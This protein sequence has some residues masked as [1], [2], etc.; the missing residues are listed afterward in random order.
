MAHKT[1]RHIWNM[2]GYYSDVFSDIIFTVITLGLFVNRVSS[3]IEKSS[4]Y[5]ELNILL[6]LDRD[7]DE[8]MILYIAFFVVAVFWIS[9]KVRQHKQEFITRK[10][11]T[12][13]FIDIDKNL[14]TLNEKIDDMHEDIKK[15]QKGNRDEL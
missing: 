14:T 9:S 7:M 10:I 3:L 1:I 4:E 12:K 2:V 11:M 13:T 8:N 6:L 5:P 15:L